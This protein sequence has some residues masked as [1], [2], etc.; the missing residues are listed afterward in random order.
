M[1]YLI[2]THLS[3]DFH[4]LRGRT[5]IPILFAFWGENLFWAVDNFWD[6]CVCWRGATL[7]GWIYPF[8]DFFHLGRSWR[9]SGFSYGAERY[10]ILDRKNDTRAQ[11]F[12]INLVKRLVASSLLV[13]EQLGWF[14][15]GGR[16]HIFAIGHRWWWI[17]YINLNR[18]WYCLEW[19]SKGPVF[20]EYFYLEVV[21]VLA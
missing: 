1:W 10:V 4:W 20:L 9:E 21:S 15:V 7:H 12:F 18:N 6:I 16:L 2:F 13:D 8:R 11:L 3:W 5:W 14:F 19:G 17:N